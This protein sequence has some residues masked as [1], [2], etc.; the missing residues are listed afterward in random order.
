MRLDHN[1][2][3]RAYELDSC[4][5]ARSIRNKERASWDL[6]TGSHGV[7]GEVI[8]I[9]RC[10]GWVKGKGSHG[11][12]G[13]VNGTVQVDLLHLFQTPDVGVRPSD[14]LS[15]QPQLA[16]AV[17]RQKSL[18]TLWITIKHFFVS[19]ALESGNFL[20]RRISRTPVTSESK[21]QMVIIC[22][23]A[24]IERRSSE[25]ASLKLFKP[26][27]PGLLA[28]VT[29]T[30]RENTMNVI[31]AEIFMSGHLRAKEL[32][33]TYHQKAKNYDQKKS[34]LGDANNTKIGVYTCY[35]LS[36]TALALPNDGK[37]MDIQIKD[38]NKAKRTKPS[39]RLEEREKMKPKAYLLL[40]ANTNLGV[41]S[42]K[43]TWKRSKG[44]RDE[45][46]SLLQIKGVD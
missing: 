22:L 32:P 12:L 17:S 40:W 5:V 39:T 8:G 25:G 30:F 11:V 2:R 38:K 14:R 15:A 9:E 3:L 45:L 34:S 13:E 29:R 28:K 35:S 18:L 43:E 41:L 16:A 21:K 23:R 44:S 7:L 46:R 33:L 6:G 19:G 1:R 20:I 27:K 31:E 10:A 24:A 26:D 37:V 42:A 4:H 36:S